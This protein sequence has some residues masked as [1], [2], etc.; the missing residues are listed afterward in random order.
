[1]YITLLNPDVNR[2]FRLQLASGLPP[3]SGSYRFRSTP[4]DWCLGRTPYF[5]RYVNA[6]FVP[7]FGGVKLNV[8]YGAV[9]LS[10]I[11]L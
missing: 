7:C 9:G 3:I 8:L 6:G 1:L 11:L 4:V 10:G 2:E 5:S